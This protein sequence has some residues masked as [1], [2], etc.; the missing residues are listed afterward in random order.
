MIRLPISYDPIFF[1]LLFR[2][3][4]SIA[5]LTVEST[6]QPIMSRT[7][8][9]FD[10]ELKVSDSLPLIGRLVAD[11]RRPLN[12]YRPR[13]SQQPDQ[14]SPIP[15]NFKLNVVSQNST[16]AS[17]EAIRTAKADAGLGSIFELAFATD[18][19]ST[20]AISANELKTYALEQYNDTW[21]TVKREYETEIRSFVEMNNGK[22]Y[23]MVSLKTATTSVIERGEEHK[24]SGGGEIS[25]PLTAVTGGAVPPFISDPHARSEGIWSKSTTNKGVF[26]AEVALA[27]EYRVI[28]LVSKYKLS[29][30]KLI[31][32][33]QILEDKGLFEQSREGGLAFSGEDDS[34]AEEDSD[35]GEKFI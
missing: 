1:F 25:I 23:F 24:K 11:P 9:V 20:Y 19:K 7:F 3:T 15:D 26:E 33:K 30:T 17:T 2:R 22:A 6:E 12:N 34:D 13:R 4:H 16:S 10:T 35:G 5:E 31:S 28:N 29:S 27:A 14:K 21:E 18:T 8:C 32:R